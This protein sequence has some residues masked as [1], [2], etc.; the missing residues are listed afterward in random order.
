MKRWVFLLAVLLV[1]PSFGSEEHP[2]L[3]AD[4]SSPRAT[5]NSFIENCETA[6]NLLQKEGRSTENKQMIL[7]SRQ[8]VR[9][10]M[11]CLDLSET[12]EFRRDNVAKEAAVALKE[13]LDRI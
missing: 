5:L 11:R 10:I 7:E 4:T 1:F 12:A 3:P 13:V 2:L 6:Y 9:R 8:A